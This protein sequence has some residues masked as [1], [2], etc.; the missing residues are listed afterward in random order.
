MRTQL[1]VLPKIH[2][3]ERCLF[4]GLLYSCPVSKQNTINVLV[5]VILFLL[6]QL[7]EGTLNCLVESFNQTVCLRVVGCRNPVVRLGQSKQ[8]LA[9]TVDEFT[10][11]VTDDNLSASIP[12]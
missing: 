12:G 3:F 4:G 1:Q 6:H 5:P 7:Q 2:H 8:V 9:H 10:P 11:L